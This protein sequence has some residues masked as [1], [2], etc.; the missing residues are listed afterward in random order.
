M[1]SY[2]RKIAPVALITAGIVVLLVLVAS[3]SGDMVPIL[4][5]AELLGRLASL[6]FIALVVG[7]L[8]G[9]VDDLN[10]RFS[11]WLQSRRKS[12]DER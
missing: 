5:N 7:L 11:D 1:L 3:G 4:I 12:R 9:V 8:C 2:L 6:I 10:D